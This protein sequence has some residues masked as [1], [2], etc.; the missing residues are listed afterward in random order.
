MA[1]PSAELNRG[2]PP[3]AHPPT[4]Q[5]TLPTGSVT[6]IVPPEL[7]RTTMSATGSVDTGAVAARYPK[8]VYSH[9]SSSSPP[10]GQPMEQASLAGPSSPAGAAMH[11]CLRSATAPHVQGVAVEIQMATGSPPT[12]GQKGSLSSQVAIY[13]SRSAGTSHHDGFRNCHDSYDSR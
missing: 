7:Q 12:H 3:A 8:P 5:S 11:S 2:L 6:L 10:T 1:S 4:K 13:S 9:A